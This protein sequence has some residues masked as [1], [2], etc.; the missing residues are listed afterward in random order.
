[1][2]SFS[3][4]THCLSTMAIDENRFVRIFRKEKR[5]AEKA[6]RGAKRDVKRTMHN[7]ENAFRPPWYQRAWDRIKRPFAR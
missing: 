7:V 3:H 6:A 4:F 1:M 2:T 5:N